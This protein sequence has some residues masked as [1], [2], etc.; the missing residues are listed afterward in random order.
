MKLKI[1]N[2]LFIIILICMGVFINGCSGKES[3]KESRGLFSWKNFEVSEGHNELFKTMKEF[4][5]N[6]LYQ[7]FSEDLREDDIKD[8]LVEAEK[9]KIDV[10]LLTGSPEWALDKAGESMCR[11]VEKAIKINK[12]V[13][14]DQGVKGILID[15]EPYLLKE[16]D[17]KSRQK[18][19]NTFVKGM[20]KTYEKARESGLEVVLCIPYFYDDLGVTKQL[21]DLIESSCDSVAIMNYYQGK[22]YENIK[23]E[24]KLAEECRKKIINVYEMKAPGTHDLKDKNTYYEEGIKAV[25]ENFAA[26]REAFHSQDIS[27]AFHDYSA[28]KEVAERE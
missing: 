25:E 8:F 12:A 26:L 6:T 24:A 22:E 1:I 23:R 15:V 13:K 14:E 4:K 28:L 10:Y 7:E 9:E 3:F 11:R 19:M 18:I 20:Q 5:L 21:E 27:L 2:G 16:W 17:K